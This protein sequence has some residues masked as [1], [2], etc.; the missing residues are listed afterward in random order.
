MTTVAEEAVARARAAFDR[1]DR[2]AAW[3]SLRTR[4]R[5]SPDEPAYRVA[6]VETYRAAGHPDQ[7]ARW[8]ASMPELLTDHERVLLHR[9]ARRAR[10]RRDLRTYLAL[11]EV[12]VEL[13][14]LVAL[15]PSAR[16]R[17]ECAS[18]RRAGE[19]ATAAAVVGVLSAIGIGIGIIVTLVQA[20]LG[21]R[22]HEFAQVT[23]VGAL[24]A[25]VGI[26][27]LL[28]VAAGLRRRWTR[29]VLLVVPV[30]AA[31][32]VLAHADMT[33]TLPFG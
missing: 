10:N 23:A 15:Q 9:F 20:F 14:E 5:R 33:T 19:F 24:F 28:V 1:G 11:A 13:V 18:E 2:R 22:A 16:E 30:V 27:A 8:G 7:A 17:S 31:V 21:G 26:G 32:V 25:V 3:E 29:T 12:P 4:A 6:L